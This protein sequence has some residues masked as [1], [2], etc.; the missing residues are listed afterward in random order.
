MGYVLWRVL[1]KGKKA[2][3]KKALVL[4]SDQSAWSTAGDGAQPR[5]AVMGVQVW[6]PVSQGGETQGTKKKN[7]NYGRA[8][9][10]YISKKW[11]HLLN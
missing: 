5:G 2:Q 1:F 9:N 6:E 7:Q 3:T 8:R 11:Y 10:I 4:P